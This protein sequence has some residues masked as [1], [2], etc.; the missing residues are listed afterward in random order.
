[1]SSIT[2]VAPPKASADSY[3]E[4]REGIGNHISFAVSQPSGRSL[5]FQHQNFAPGFYW[6]DVF[7]FHA[8][9]KVEL[10]FQSV[11]VEVKGKNLTVSDHCSFNEK[12]IRL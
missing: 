6:P 10:S 4:S 5:P 1:V 7:L 3:L 9:V 8:R 12:L 2:K 11:L